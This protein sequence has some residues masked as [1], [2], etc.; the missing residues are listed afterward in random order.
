MNQLPTVVRATQSCIGYGAQ[1][2]VPVAL[3]AV[4]SAAP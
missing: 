2:T 3:T 1:V 4:S